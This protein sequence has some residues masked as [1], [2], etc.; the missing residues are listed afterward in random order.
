L[1][2]ETIRL[3]AEIE[4]LTGSKAVLQTEIERLRMLNDDLYAQSERLRAELADCKH[5]WLEMLGTEWSP[6]VHRRA[7]EPKP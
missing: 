5:D 4:Q 1:Y 7:L 6:K 2:D 3:Q